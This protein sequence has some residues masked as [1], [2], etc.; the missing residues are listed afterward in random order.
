MLNKDDEKGLADLD[1]ADQDWLRGLAG[2]K[3]PGA[4]PNTMRQVS[5][6]REAIRAEERLQKLTARL[7][8]HRMARRVKYHFIKLFSVD[9]VGQWK[10]AFSAVFVGV[11]LG[12]LLR[13]IVPLSGQNMSENK[14]DRELS[15]ELPSTAPQQKAAD[16]KM[17]RKWPDNFVPSAYPQEIATQLKAEFISAGAKVEMVQMPVFRLE[18]K[19]PDNPSEGLRDLCDNYDIE[20]KEDRSSP[21][22]ERLLVVPIE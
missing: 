7:F 1:K 15:D 19:M 5:G 9:Y 10:V 17:D 11:I 2:E 12:W 16:F 3:V 21:Q 6:V 22:I 8:W 20:L 4:D 14:A 13:P 18:M